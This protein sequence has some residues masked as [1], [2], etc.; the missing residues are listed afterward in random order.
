[1]HRMAPS[2]YMKNNNSDTFPDAKHLV[3][4]CF[5]LEL[6]VQCLTQGDPD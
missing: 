2:L 5:P 6:D 4:L 1:M 3:E